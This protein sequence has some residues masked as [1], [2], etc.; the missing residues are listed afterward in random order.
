MMNLNINLA[1]IDIQIVTY[2]SLTTHELSIYTDGSLDP[3]KI[4]D[5]TGE[6]IMGC[7][8]INTDTE[9]LSNAESA[10]SLHLPEQN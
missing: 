8:W 4:K 6:V 3:N 2:I 7:G 5:H 10:C 9:R 1:T